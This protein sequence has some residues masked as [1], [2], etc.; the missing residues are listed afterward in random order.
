MMIKQLLWVGLGGGLGSILRFLVSVLTAKQGYVG[1]FPL[2][3][4]SVNLT[5]CLL[6]GLL[7][8]YSYR[9]GWLDADMKLLLI[10][11]FCGGY[12]TFSTFS[13]ENLHLLETHQYLPFAL[14][15]SGSLLLGAGAVALGLFLSK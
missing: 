9:Y 14:Y 5:G 8:G 4:F 12:T 11:G 13:L 6:I 2:A 15:L 3:T 10:T 1:A 7:T